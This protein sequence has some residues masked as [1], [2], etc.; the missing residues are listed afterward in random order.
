MNLNQLDT[1]INIFSFNKFNIFSFYDKDHGARD[2]SFLKEWVIENLKKFNI[3]SI[4]LTKIKMLCYP[5]IFGYVF[6]PLSIF[7]CYEEKIN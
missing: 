6:N 3:K 1:K 4:K 2:G 5:R 7:Y